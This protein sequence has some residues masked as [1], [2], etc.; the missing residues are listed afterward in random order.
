[1]RLEKSIYII[2]FVCV[3][4]T[5]AFFY[6][7][8]KMSQLNSTV[9]LLAHA[10]DIDDRDEIDRVKTDTETNKIEAKK[11]SNLLSSRY[12]SLIENPQKNPLK[13]EQYLRKIISQELSNYFAEQGQTSVSQ[14][15][16]INALTVSDA[17][18]LIAV[19]EQLET[20]KSLGNINSDDMDKFHLQV[21]KLSAHDRTQMLRALSQEIN[22]DR[23]KVNHLF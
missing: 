19:S 13:N 23:I 16:Q 11:N 3:V 14:N 10:Q 4:Q 22:S 7:V 2:S 8:S 6:I 12:E 15:S 21:S 9:A 1:M 20:Y 17:D 18:H 5:F